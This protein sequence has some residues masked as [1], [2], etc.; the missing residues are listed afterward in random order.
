MRTLCVIALFFVG[1]TTGPKRPTTNTSVPSLDTSKEI[2]R[3]VRSNIV[4]SKDAIGRSRR[5]NR[6]IE[7]KLIILQNKDW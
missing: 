4:D 5:L 3:T 2:N 6:Q 7:D 1:C